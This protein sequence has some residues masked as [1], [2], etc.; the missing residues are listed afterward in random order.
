MIRV[1]NTTVTWH[2]AHS[3]CLNMGFGRMMHSTNAGDRVVYTRKVLIENGWPDVP[4]WI[5]Y[6]KDGS[7]NKWNKVSTTCSP[8]S[9]SNLF[10]F[11][12][13]LP[14]TQLCVL[15]NMTRAT[16]EQAWYGVPCN[17]R[18]AFICEEPVAVKTTKTNDAALISGLPTS[19]L[20]TTYD[21]LT[22]CCRAKILPYVNI[23]VVQVN[24]ANGSCVHLSDDI[25]NFPLPYYV[26]TSV[27]GSNVI[28]ANTVMTVVVLDDNGTIDYT[29]NTD[30]SCI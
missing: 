3:A 1:V 9:N 15:V 21:C 30:L 25:F 11:G 18:H 12:N 2:E 14:D 13:D 24:L 28:A 16:S 26:N 19:K 6:L 5:G 20:T 10:K 7:T 29:S 22:A 8:I 17:E 23:P 4:L 27:T